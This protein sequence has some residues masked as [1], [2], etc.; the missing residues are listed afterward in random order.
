MD[1]KKSGKVIGTSHA[2]ISDDGKILSGNPKKPR[3]YSEY[4][5]MIRGRNV[6]SPPTPP[7]GGGHGQTKG[8]VACPN[9]GAPLNISMTGNCTHCSVKVTSGEF[10]WVLSKIEQD[11]TYRG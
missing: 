8:D 4:W 10:D 1:T 9:C 3:F 7:L 5:T 2:K 6:V 11:D